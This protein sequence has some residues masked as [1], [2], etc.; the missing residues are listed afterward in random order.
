[1]VR[2]KAR[3]GVNATCALFGPD[4]TMDPAFHCYSEF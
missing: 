1:L 2:I 4:K 3:M